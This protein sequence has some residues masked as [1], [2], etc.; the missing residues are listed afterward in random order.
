VTDDEV[1]GHHVEGRVSERQ[2]RQGAADRRDA[3]APT[4]SETEHRVVGDNATAAKPVRRAARAT[5]PGP[6]PTSSIERPAA[7][8]PSDVSSSS[9]GPAHNR[10]KEASYASAVPAQLVD[11]AAP[12]LLPSRPDA[13][14]AAGFSQPWLGCSPSAVARP[15]G[16]RSGEEVRLDL[17]EPGTV[18]SRAI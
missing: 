9:T 17:V 4:V 12:Y 8:G 15:S 10:A 13:L 11:I 2:V 1:G 6:Q 3:R 18:G 5:V 14:R 16:R 7:G